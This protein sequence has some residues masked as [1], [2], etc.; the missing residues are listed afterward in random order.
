METRCEEKK[1]EKEK[2][3][4]KKGK[5]EE[6]KKWRRVNL[7]EKRFAQIESWLCRATKIFSLSRR[8]DEALGV[9]CRSMLGRE[10]GW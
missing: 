3:G 1:R 9:V 7:D 5:K 10:G 8:R 2:K 6:G 4:R